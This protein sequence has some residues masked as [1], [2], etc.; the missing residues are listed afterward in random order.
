MSSNIATAIDNAIPEPHAID[1]PDMNSDSIVSDWYDGRTGNELFFGPEKIEYMLSGWTSK[2]PVSGLTQSAQ[3]D[4][5]Y[6]FNSQYAFSYT[7]RWGHTYKTYIRRYCMILEAKIELTSHFYIDDDGAMGL[8]QYESEEYEVN[9]W[10]VFRA[11]AYDTG[12][13]TIN[14]L[15]LLSDP[16]ANA[17]ARFE[18][19][20]GIANQDGYTN[21]AGGTHLIYVLYA[22]APRTSSMQSTLHRAVASAFTNFYT[23][24]CYNG[25]YVVPNSTSMINDFSTHVSVESFESTDSLICFPDDCNSEPVILNYTGSGCAGTS[26]SYLYH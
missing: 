4:Y 20:L 13:A 21:I 23:P 22:T 7:Q 14:H 10:K 19:N 25:T 2:V 16:I 11:S 3:G 5:L 18:R 9:G 8:G 6:Q 15:V 12:R 1:W 26:L 24:I 17:G